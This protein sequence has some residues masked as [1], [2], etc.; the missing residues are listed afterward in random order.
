MYQVLFHIPFTAGLVPPDG[1]PVYGFGA[2]MFLTFVLTAMVWGPLRGARIGVPKDKMQ[3]FAILLFLCGFA[4]AR[5]LYM[6]QYSDQ[7]PD[8]S[9]VG[10][11]KA[12]F[13][14]WNGGI[15]LYGSVFGG[16]IAFLYFYRLVLR[17]LHVSAWKFADVVAP[18]IALG[19]AV[20]RI[21]CYLNGCCWGQPVCAECQP[22]PL[23][24]ALGEFPLLPAHAQKQ[25]CVLPS[26]TDRMPQIHG[27]QTPTG[28]SIT[29]ANNLFGVGD[30]RS[31][32]DAIEPGSDA[33]K[34][35]LKPG[36]RVIRVNG[37][38][39]Q[40]V[41]ELSGDPTGVEQTTTKLVAE[42]GTI[43]DRPAD[44]EDV[45]S[46]S[47]V[48]FNDPATYQNAVAK[49]GRVPSGVNPIVHDT[50]WETVRAWP[51]GRAE[52]DLVV[53]RD[54]KEVAIG[55]VPTRYPS[56]RRSCTRP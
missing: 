45:R 22:V 47:W 27:L 11:I 43:P 16:L 8:K 42:G 30:P 18:L 48:G 20:G 12:F 28:F 44:A 50:L 15:V 35:G 10:L 29:P 37:R 51:R 21:G 53:N 3:D 31:V 1:L 13:Q 23:S 56:S 19:I 25:V 36:D 39:N 5:V 6:V 7:F 4:G 34:A 46:L 49:I 52:L 9:I 17:K 54:G 40:I 14:I 38:V 33:G 2:M 24:P 55:F 26:A 32:V 41:I